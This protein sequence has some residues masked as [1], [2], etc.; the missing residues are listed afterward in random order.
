[1]ALAREVSSVHSGASI[2]VQRHALREALADAGY[3]PVDVVRASHWLRAGKPA[4]Y[5]WDV[6]F[7]RGMATTE[8]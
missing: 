3:T 4:D 1:V 7:G 5:R 8:E 2:E 6:R